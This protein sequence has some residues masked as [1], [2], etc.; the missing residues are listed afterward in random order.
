M[1]NE[2][3]VKCRRVNVSGFGSIEIPKNAQDLDFLNVAARFLGPDVEDATYVPTV[4]PIQE[5][6][7]LDGWQCLVTWHGLNGPSERYIVEASNGEIF[8]IFQNLI[9]V[10]RKISSHCRKI[11]GSDAKESLQCLVNI[12]KY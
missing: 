7:E 3:F 2:K 1:R 10:R 9:F 4:V 11:S 8:N 5:I 6:E 12:E